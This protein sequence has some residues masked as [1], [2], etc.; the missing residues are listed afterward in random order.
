MDPVP[1]FLSWYNWP[2]V[3]WWC[4]IV[5]GLA[6]LEFPLVTIYLDT[7][8]SRKSMLLSTSSSMSSSFEL[9]SAIFT[10]R[11][12]MLRLRCRVPTLVLLSISSITRLML[13]VRMSSK[14]K[15]AL[16]MSSSYW[17]RD[18]W[19]TEKTISLLRLMFGKAKVSSHLGFCPLWVEVLNSVCSSSF[20]LR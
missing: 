11:L 7:S 19:Y 16:P 1:R 6:F 18:L 20:A 8:W 3:L 12:F 9:V 4:A 14:M 15:M 10:M 2:A 5:S 17:K 13:Y